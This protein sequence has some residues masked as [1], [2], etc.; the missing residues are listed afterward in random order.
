MPRWIVPDRKQTW[1]ALL[2]DNRDSH[3]YYDVYVKNRDGT[4]VQYQRITNTVADE[5]INS[6]IVYRQLFPKKKLTTIRGIFQRNLETFERSEI[7]TLR[8]GT[9]RCVNCLP[10][11]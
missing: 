7:V 2:R 10:R 8:D 5:P 6:Y 1:R 3:L 9:F 11:K 4:W